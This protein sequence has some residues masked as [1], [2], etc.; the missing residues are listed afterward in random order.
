MSGKTPEI[1]IPTHIF[2]RCAMREFKLRQ[3]S[4]CEGCDHFRGLAE[5]MRREGQALPFESQF[6]LRC[7][8]PVD[9]ELYHVQIETN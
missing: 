4:Q 8:Y 2:V 5:R 7:A 1:D 6:A 9:R 3:A